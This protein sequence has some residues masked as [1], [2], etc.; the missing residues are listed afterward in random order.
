MAIEEVFFRDTHKEDLELKLILSKNYF[1]SRNGRAEG[2][3]LLKRELENCVEEKFGQ[4]L[5]YIGSFLKFLGGLLS[6]N[7]PKVTLHILEC[8]DVLLTHVPQ[9][10]KLDR[11]I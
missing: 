10:N 2:S 7:N 11:F 9:V 4:L 1:F 3:L 5:P 8:H 6:D